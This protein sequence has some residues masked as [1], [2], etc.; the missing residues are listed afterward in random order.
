[1]LRQTCLVHGSLNK[2]IYFGFVF[3]CRGYNKRFTVVWCSLGA[4]ERTEGNPHA[5]FLLSS[6]LTIYVRSPEELGSCR[7]TLSRLSESQLIQ[8]Q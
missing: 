7:T 1:M 6:K 8:P 4:C 5:T 3:A 2:D